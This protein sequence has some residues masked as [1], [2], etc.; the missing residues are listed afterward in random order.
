MHVYLYL[1]SWYVCQSIPGL[2]RGSPVAAYPGIILCMSEY[3]RIPWIL[4]QGAPVAAYPGI[5][6]CMSEYPKIP[7]MLYQ[8]GRCHC[9]SLDNP[10]YVR[11]SQYFTKGVSCPYVSWDMYVRVCQDSIDTI[12]KWYYQCYSN[13]CLSIPR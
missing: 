12:P 5:I 3:P 6:L 7:R 1:L 2:P 13:V 9:L 8:R 11:V 10:M 4:Y